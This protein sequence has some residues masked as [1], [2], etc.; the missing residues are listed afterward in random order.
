[1]K[2]L[3]IYPGVRW[4]A[5]I[6]LLGM[7]TL[8]AQSQGGGRAVSLP[9]G[10][11]ALRDLAYVTNGH[12]RQKLDLYLPEKSGKL[13]LIIMIHGGAFMAGDKGGENPTRFLAACRA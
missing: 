12:P 3:T 7:L 5:L 4:A 9:A 1:M 8:S 11:R 2:T 6:L 10:A 13:P